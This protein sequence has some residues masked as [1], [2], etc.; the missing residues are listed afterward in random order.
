MTIEN[1]RRSVGLVV[2]QGR[3]LHYRQSNIV[4]ELAEARVAVSSFACVIWMMGHPRAALLA[5][6]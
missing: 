5:H 6:Y 2:S 3:V 1:Q 4:V